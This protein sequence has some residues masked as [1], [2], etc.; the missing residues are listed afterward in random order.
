M[1]KRS[2]YFENPAYISTKQSQLIIKFPEVERNL[3]HSLCERFSNNIPIEDI[4]IVILDNQQIT[5]TQGALQ[6]LSENNCAVILCD[7]NRMPSGYLLPLSSNTLQGERYRQQIGSSAPLKKQLWQ[8]TIQSKIY[9]QASLLRKQNCINTLN[10]SKW[11]KEVKS[12]DSSNLE[13]RAA[14][15]YWSNLFPRELSFTRDRFNSPPNNLLNYGYS[16]LRSVIARSL[17]GSGLLPSLGIHHKNRYNAFALADDIMEPYR[18]FIDNIVLGIVKEGCDFSEISKEIKIKLLSIPVIDVEINN[19]RRPLSI[20]A[21]I[22]TAS[23][24]KCF[25]KEEARISYPVF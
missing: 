17:V 12:G 2:L 22:T 6:A 8:Q 25:A 11:I 5:I 15:F 19:L 4:G 10:M 18:P 16:V 21:G 3:P 9:N 24:Y 7:S 1:I 13:A 14:V 20:A 23:L